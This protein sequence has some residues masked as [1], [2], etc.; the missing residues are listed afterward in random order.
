[1]RVASGAVVPGE[2]GSSDEMRVR[3]E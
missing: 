1:V 2:L 3:L